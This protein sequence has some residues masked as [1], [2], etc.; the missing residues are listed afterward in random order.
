MPFPVPWLEEKLADAARADRLAHAY[1]L[2]GA[3]LP[4]LEDAFHR[5]AAVLL[6]SSDRNHP[7]LHTVRPESKSRRIVIDQI[8]EM[9]KEL[10]LKSHGQGRK[11]AGILAAD[12]MCLPPANAAN[13]FLK[14]LE[15]PPA[16]CVIFLATDRPEQLLPT[17]Q[18]RCLTL[19]IE[20]PRTGSATPLPAEWLREW[21]AAGDGTP[22]AAYRRARLLEALLRALRSLAENEVAGA[23]KS[24]DIEDDA[25]AALVESEYIQRRDQVLIALT[26][27]A[28]QAAEGSPQ[29]ALFSTAKT[30]LALEDLRYALSRNLDQALAVERCCLRMS[31]LVA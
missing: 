14:T 3:D 10:Q 5:L 24:Q 12:R 20:S 16:Q 2:T 17:I 19:H 6:G 22:D 28:W 7:D 26:R 27:A 11:V 4:V 15:E 9:E 1:L 21:E 29:N 8:R 18:S 23:T 25:L 31:G 13:A 30:C